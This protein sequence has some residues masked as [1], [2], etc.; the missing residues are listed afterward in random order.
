MKRK[1]GGTKTQQWKTL[2][3]MA[4]NFPICL[5]LS[6]YPIIN[7]R[8][9]FFVKSCM[10]WKYGCINYQKSTLIRMNSQKT[11]F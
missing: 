5:W 9:F 8:K 3:K 10:Y 7:V 2:E 1:T 11:P 6:S 4:S